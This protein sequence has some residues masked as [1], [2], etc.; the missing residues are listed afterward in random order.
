MLQL[1]IRFKSSN[2]L[3]KELRSK[4]IDEEIY[5]YI[6]YICR[7]IVVLFFIFLYFSIFLLLTCIIIF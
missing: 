1:Q 6:K 5:L 7:R 2:V 4:L 3:E